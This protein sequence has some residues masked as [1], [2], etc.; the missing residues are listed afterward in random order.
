MSDFIDSQRSNGGFTETAPYVGIADAGLGGDSGPIGWQTYLPVALTWLYKYYSNL[1]A[2]EDAY[3]AATAYANFIA[4]APAA[5]IENGLGDW[6][7]LEPS[8]LAL[9][10][11]GFEMMSY[12]A[13]ANIS[14]ALGHVSDGAKWA[15]AAA[16]SAASINARFLDAS[17]GAYHGPG[18]NGTQC[19]QAMPLFLGIVPDSNRTAVLAV[20]EEA[21]RARGGHL[22]VGSFGLKVCVAACRAMPDSRVFSK[23]IPQKLLPVM[24]QVFCS[25]HAICAFVS[26]CARLAPYHSYAV[27]PYVIG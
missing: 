19:A 2:M 12:A 8:A 1:G 22:S 27:A 3:V 7:T 23:I 18:F 17:T 14:N 26:E 16:V 4:T 9:T 20:L 10:G 13:I 24:R 11:R 6:M 15:A 21:I 5:A 25:P